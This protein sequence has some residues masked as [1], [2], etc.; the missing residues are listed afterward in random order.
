MILFTDVSAI[1][2]VVDW[3]AFAKTGGRGAQLR[4]T[5]GNDKGRDTQFANNVRRARE[6]GLAV[7]PYHF[8]YPLPHLSPREQAIRAFVDSEGLG[9]NKG[10][11]PPL[12]DLE[13][14]PR[15]NP[16]EALGT[17]W[18][19]WKCFDSQIRDWGLQYVEDSLELTG[20]RPS[21]YTYPWF[22]DTIEGK[23]APEYAKCRLHI[24]HYPAKFANKVPVDGDRPMALA[25]W[26]AATMWQ[27]NGNGGMKFSNGVDADFNV[28]M[29]DEEAWHKLL[30][31]EG[32]HV[33]DLPFD[34]NVLRLENQTL[35]VEEDIRNRR[36][37]L[38]RE[39]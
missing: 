14:P 9:M 1:Q 22:W 11:L 10:D 6:A 4:C 19:K 7:G 23:K 34:P 24:A 15:E 20:I 16:G 28:F 3:A 32:A 31:L 2:G 38:A 30:G 26:T 12:F 37:D 25:P 18:K 35:V 36:R 29:G 39:A 13:W 8:A 17:Q 21:I 27:F 33:E 5:V